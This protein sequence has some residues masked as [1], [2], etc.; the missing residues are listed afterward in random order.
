MGCLGGGSRQGWKKVRHKGTNMET[1][2][3]DDCLASN[4]MSCSKEVAGIAR[5]KVSG[6]EEEW[7]DAG[8]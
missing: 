5:A 6:V 4:P 3:E 8:C 7:A 2:D 1:A